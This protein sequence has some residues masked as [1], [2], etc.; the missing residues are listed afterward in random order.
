MMKKALVSIIL[1][2][3]MLAVF[4]SI[5]VTAQDDELKITVSSD[6]HFQ[7]LSDLNTLQEEKAN[8]ANT[9]GMLNREMFF[10]ATTQGQMNFESSAIMHKLLDEFENNDS[11][12][13]IIS[14]DL[15]CGKR[16]SHLE[17]AKILSEAEK[18]SGKE[19][20]VINGNHDCYAE[21]TDLHITIDEFKEI[22]ADF[23][24]N[25]ALNCDENSGSYSVDLDKSHRL[26]AI[27]SCIYGKDDGRISD[28]TLQWM[29]FECAKA[30][31]D[32]KEI[33]AMMHHSI[34]PHFALQPMI[35]NYE[36]IAKD[37]SEMGINL[38]YTGHIH[39]NDIS[40]A[41]INGK[42]LYDVQTGSLI[43]SPNAYRTVVYS[44]NEV[45]ISSR[46][47]TEIDTKYLAD[48]YTNEQLNAIT[49]D[50]SKYSYD[51]F[52][53]GVCRWL[54]RYIG[55]AG[56]VGKLMKLDPESREYAFV[57]N[58]LLNVGDAL[59]MPIYDDGK[60]P[61]VN[62]S[63]EELAEIAGCTLPETDYERLYQ[64]AFKV[65]IG[66]YNG[67]EDTSVN[68]VE[69]PFLFTCLKS[70]LALSA[71]NM[72]FNNK[73]MKT[74]DSFNYSLTGIKAEDVLFNSLLRFNYSDGLIDDIVQAVLSPLLE[75]FSCD[76]SEPEDIE[77][78]ISFDAPSPEITVPLTVFDKIMN[79]VVKFLNKFFE[80]A[81]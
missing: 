69:I 9:N 7:C 68:D 35:D 47:I 64:A 67:D 27:D 15:T 75:G 31:A 25:Q 16:Q 24:Y 57:N 65:M 45:K 60:T 26:L 52:E 41:E 12:Y 48:G 71:T 38:V 53:S 17:L 50:F 55:S 33:I 46:Y 30:E 6:T 59:A 61:G 51:F 37:F 72:I 3:S 29:K 1:C 19:I 21:S 79:F 34:L 10:Y 28:S 5:G 36:N 20:F 78:T 66:F 58:L 11:E 40:S 56:K 63:I 74:V 14:G 13:L 62:D 8:E 4:F 44:G 18:K 70:V 22:Y 81:L 54:N 42:T 39:A 76:L 77:L 43:S 73:V 80:V 2:I 49:N 23:G 32:G